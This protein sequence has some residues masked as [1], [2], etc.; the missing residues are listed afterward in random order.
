MQTNFHNALTRVIQF[1][2]THRRS[3]KNTS[4]EKEQSIVKLKKYLRMKWIVL[5]Y[6]ESYFE[7]TKGILVQIY[8]FS[9][10]QEYYK[11]N[12]IPKCVRIINNFSVL[13]ICQH[14][15]GF[16]VL[17]VYFRLC[18][19]PIEKMEISPVVDDGSCEQGLGY[20]PV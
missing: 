11:T 4:F 9:C 19:V 14:F 12:S 3:Y 8:P 7:E 13:F 18:L 2:C 10:N 16:S 5:L 20:F 17:Y 6:S 1:A 15:Y